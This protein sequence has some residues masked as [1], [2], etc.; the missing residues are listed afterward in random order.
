MKRRRQKR[1]RDPRWRR[2]PHIRPRQILIAAA[3]VFSRDGLER[4]KLDSVAREAGI[5]KGTIYL[6]YRNKND[7]FVATLH[8][9][10]DRVVRTLE[11]AM[12]GKA[13]GRFRGRIIR[14][15]RKVSRIINAPETLRTL[16]MVLA[17]AGTFPR[18]S[19]L[20]YREFILKNNRALA[21]LLARGISAGEIRKVDTMVAARCLAGMILVFVLS[22]RILGGARIFPISQDRVIRTATSIF[23][24]GV[25][26][27]AG[28][29]ISSRRPRGSRKRK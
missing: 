8:R 23:L 2:L 7:L 14:I 13:R 5:T 24:D 3:K 22:Q 11:A 28:R 6:Y 26:R 12:S 21:E 15:V 27:P 1:A 16:R 18:A 25:S 17:E 4:A 10:R 29:R 20:F 9:M 19:R